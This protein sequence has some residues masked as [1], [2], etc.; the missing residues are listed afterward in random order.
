MIVW[1]ASDNC[2]DQLDVQCRGLRSWLKV[3]PPGLE[4]SHENQPGEKRSRIDVPDGVNECRQCITLRSL[5]ASY[6]AWRK[7]T[8][9]VQIAWV[10]YPTSLDFPPIRDTFEEGVGKGVVE[11]CQPLVESLVD[12][13]V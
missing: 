12:L 7:L 4:L 11:G 9:L 2:G 8:Q 1:Q 5:E 10:R 13:D 6:C 3:S